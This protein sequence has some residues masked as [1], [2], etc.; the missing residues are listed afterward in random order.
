VHYDSVIE[1][2]LFRESAGL[3]FRPTIECATDDL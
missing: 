2:R 3:E 1:D